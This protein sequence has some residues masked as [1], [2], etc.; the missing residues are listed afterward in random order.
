MAKPGANNGVKINNISFANP[1]YIQ[2]N[3]N[4]T[5]NDQNNANSIQIPQKRQN[6]MKTGKIPKNQK[7]GGDIS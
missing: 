4:K 5:E 2:L 6:Q 1:K 3:L 7:F